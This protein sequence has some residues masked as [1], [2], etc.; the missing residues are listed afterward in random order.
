MGGHAQG[1]RPVARGDQGG[2]VGHRHRRPQAWRWPCPAEANART[3]L[4]GKIYSFAVDAELIPY[5]SNPAVRLPRWKVPP[6]DRAL[7]TGREFRV[8]WRMTDS[9]GYLTQPRPEGRQRYAW[10]HPHMDPDMVQVLRLIAMTGCR[11]QE[12]TALRWREVDLDEA[13]I[14]LPSARVK[15]KREHMS[16]ISGSTLAARI[17]APN[18]HRAGRVAATALY[19]S[20]PGRLRLPLAGGDAGGCCHLCGAALVRNRQSRPIDSIEHA[21]FNRPFLIPEDERRI[22]FCGFNGTN[23]L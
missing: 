13:H 5:N 10:R 14:V 19:G 23:A 12:I 21:G 16:S 1:K 8:F 11:I 15:N 20:T 6:R 22:Q 17:A 3:A 7:Q 18:W 4:V 9:D 2:V